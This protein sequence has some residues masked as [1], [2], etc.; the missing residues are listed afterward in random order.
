M[1]AKRNWSVMRKLLKAYQAVPAND[2]D[3]V[4]IY[5]VAGQHLNSLMDPFLM[6]DEINSE[7]VGD[8]I[9][10]FPEHP[11]RGFETITYMK[12]GRMR[13]RDHMGNEGV[14]EPGDVQWMTAGKGVLH[15]EMPEQESGLLHGFQVWLNLPAS[16]KMKPAAYRDIKSQNINELALDDG[17]LIRAIAGE[18]QVEGKALVGSLPKMQTNPVFLDVTL[19]VQADI[20]I[21]F[22]KN[23]PAMVF[24]YEGSSNE[25][26]NRTMGFYSEG[27]TLKLQASTEGFKALVF[28]GQP[29]LEPIVQYGPFVMNTP[30][31]I[32]QALMDYRNNQ[33]V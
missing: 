16:E 23:N 26:T 20:E 19:T 4:S 14:I 18:L 28:S 3:G 33:L 5:R 9:G 31:Q 11:H 17:S 21:A 32:D 27:E 30:E 7:N 2:G 22:N 24:I 8:Y 25:L 15:S 6:F 13:H 10:G 12:A 1:Q 29:L